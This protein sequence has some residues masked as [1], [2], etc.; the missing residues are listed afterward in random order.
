M[1]GVCAV[2]FTAHVKTVAAFRDH[3]QSQAGK[4]SKS[5]SNFPHSFLQK[6]IDMRSGRITELGAENIFNWGQININLVNRSWVKA[7][8]AE[9]FLVLQYE[10]APLAF[11]RL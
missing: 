8:G 10:E 1:D 11:T 7:K 6:N 5:N 3:I 4:H 9:R 2:L